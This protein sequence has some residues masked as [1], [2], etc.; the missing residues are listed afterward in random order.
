MTNDETREE[1]ARMHSERLG[2]LARELDSLAQ[3]A[4]RAEGCARTTRCFREL[5][6]SQRAHLADALE[7]V[8]NDTLAVRHEITLLRAEIPEVKEPP[9]EEG[10]PGSLSLIH[11]SEPTRR[12]H[13]SRMPSSA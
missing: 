6:P 8:V 11:I 4:R 5:T 13:V 10:D 2:R 1:L 3:S 12:H 9:P 7:A